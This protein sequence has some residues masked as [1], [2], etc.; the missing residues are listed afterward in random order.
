MGEV[1]RLNEVHS[2][3]EA[4]GAFVKIVAPGWPMILSGLKSL[5]ETGVPLP[6]SAGV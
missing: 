2:D 1:T 3:L 5:L 4:D 6:F